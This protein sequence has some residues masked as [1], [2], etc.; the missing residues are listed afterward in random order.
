MAQPYSLEIGPGPYKFTTRKLRPGETSSYAGNRARKYFVNGQEVSNSRF[1]ELK[2]IPRKKLT[3]AEMPGVKKRAIELL[4]EGLPAVEVTNTLEKEG[5]IKLKA[6]DTGTG[7]QITAR[8]N[9]NKFYKR[10]L[11]AGE[12]KVKT[13]PKMYGTS[14]GTLAEVTKRNKELIKIIN[15]NKDLNPDQIAK[16]ANKQ[17]GSTISR[18]VIVDLAR[19]EGISLTTKPAKIFEEIKHLDGLIKNNKAY[20]SAPIEK[21]TLANK[22]RFLFEKMKEKLG[23]NY[24]SG[25]FGNRLQKMAKLYVGEIGPYEKDLYKTIKAPVNY[26]DSGLHKNMVGLSKKH[27]LGVVEKARLLGLPK[28]DIKLLN[29]VLKGSRELSDLRVAGDHTDIDALMKN[30]KDYKKNYTRINIIADKLNTVKLG[31]DN[32]IIKLV[33]DYKLG[34]LT[35]AEFEKKVEAVRSAFTNKTKVP[36]GKPVIKNNKVTLDFQTERLIDLKNPR[37]TAI[38][39]ALNNLVE[40]SGVKISDFDEKL[41]K[42]TSVKER[43]SFLKNA[44]PLDLKNSKILKALSRMPGVGKLAAILIGGGTLGAV[45]LATLA[46]ATETGEG[47]R[48]ELPKPET[49]KYDK[50]LGAFVNPQTDDV[51]SQ[52]GL[53][54]WVAENPIKSVAGTA[55]TGLATKKG[56]D[57]GKGA[58]KK[59]A[60]LGMPLPTA[61]MDAYFVGR[62]IEEGKSPTEIAKDPFNWLGLATMD[63][64]TKAAG[65]TEKSGKLASALRLGMSPGM[66]R[67][68]SRFLGLP[69]L[70]LSTGL[71]AYDQYQKYKNKEG[72]VYDL[73]NREEIDNAQV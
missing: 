63:P 64:L 31:A 6:Y 43:F 34:L 35:S 30:F 40:Q 60:M 68:A 11:A 10:L 17:L 37:N 48:T 3:Y 39:Q 70:A 65:M 51:V 33:K 50:T 12:L 49:V 73:F 57:I 72:F 66:I 61:A 46:N 45:G 42:I 26:M 32:Q 25:E 53:L 71:T 28:K 67:G 69:G 36:I 19:N 29:D 58:L 27:G 24:S 14:G 44:N 20:L 41:S 9:L 4:N 47:E 22:H 15:K 13:I 7:R 18:N 59:L 38:N 62:Q 21:V 16:I 1:Y 55:A 2:N 56:R 54:D 23:K 8:S 52:A 5:L